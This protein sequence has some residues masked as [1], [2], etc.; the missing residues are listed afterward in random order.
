LRM[1]RERL[2]GRRHT[3]MQLSPLTC[4]ETQSFNIAIH[5]KIIILEAGFCE[6]DEVLHEGTQSYQQF[7][8]SSA[9][10]NR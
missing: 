9:H 7:L 2:T 10:Q 4:N 5:P 3:K 8:V 1:A 6:I